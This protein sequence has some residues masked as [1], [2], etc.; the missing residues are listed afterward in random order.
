M[1]VFNKCFLYLLSSLA[2][3]SVFIKLLH[4]ARIGVFLLASG[5][6]NLR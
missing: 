4:Y 2:K 6:I 5:K 3:N 1:K